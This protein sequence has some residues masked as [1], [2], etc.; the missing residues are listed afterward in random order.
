MN[1]DGTLSQ[2]SKEKLTRFLINLKYWWTTANVDEKNTL[3]LINQYED[4]IQSTRKFEE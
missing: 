1:K 2:E 3:T 4:F